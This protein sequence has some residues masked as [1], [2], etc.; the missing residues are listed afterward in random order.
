MADAISRLLSRHLV[1]DLHKGLLVDGNRVHE[2]SRTQ[3]GANIKVHSLGDLKL[4][5]DGL[6]FSVDSVSGEVFRNNDAV[7]AGSKLDG[8]CLFTFGGPQLAHDR[9][10]IPFFP[11]HPEVIL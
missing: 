11:S 4:A 5:Y 3:K 8:A 7:V 1:R 10:W 6:S 2:I 9:T